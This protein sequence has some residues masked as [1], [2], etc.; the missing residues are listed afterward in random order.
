MFAQVSC[1][2][3]PL[4][5]EAISR[6]LR[7]LVLLV[8][9]QIL[10]MTL[11]WAFNCRP[12]LDDQGKELPIELDKVAKVRRTFEEIEASAAISNL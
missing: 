10:A 9:Q 7:P 4:W 6:C 1:L 12:A 2:R 5:Y 11:L 3:I 8:L